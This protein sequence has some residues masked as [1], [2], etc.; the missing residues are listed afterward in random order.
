M[1]VAML[2]CN[3]T[4][5]KDWSFFLSHILP[6]VNRSAGLVH[7]GVEEAEAVTVAVVTV[8][9]EPASRAPPDSNHTEH[10]YQYSYSEGDVLVHGGREP[11]DREPIPL[12]KAV[13]YLLMA[14]LVVVLVAYA[15][16][17]HL[18]KD[19]LHEFVEWVFG[20]RSAN[21]RSK[22]DVSC[23]TAGGNQMNELPRLLDTNYAAQNHSG[24]SS[25]VKPEELVVNIDEPL[26]LPAPPHTAQGSR[27]HTLRHFDLIL[28]RKDG[29]SE[30]EEGKFTARK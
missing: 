29:G 8:A 3:T 17:G 10:V 4:A 21:R 24:C 23:I 19:L 18:V 30:S 14:A 6:L 27:S 7:R 15:I 11:P 20:P 2:S 5:I 9:L 16:V 26:H 25:A 28:H 13:L 22:S 1:E 12:P